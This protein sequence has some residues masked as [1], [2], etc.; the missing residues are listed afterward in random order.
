MRC[1]LA[2]IYKFSLIFSF[3]PDTTVGNILAPGRSGGF[4]ESYWVSRPTTADE[5][6]KWAN[7]RAQLLAGDIAITSYREA[8]YTY[9]GNKM[10]P[11]GVT[12]GNLFRPGG[13]LITTNSPD[14][15]L[16]CLARCDAANHTWNL[17]I[18]AVPDENITS[19]QFTPRP[20]WLASLN[21]YLA[22]LI[23]GADIGQKINFL[24]RDPTTAKARVLA[25]NVA[26]GVV[27]V[28][29]NLA[30][31]N[32]Q[33]FIR[34]NRVYDAAGQPV[35]GTYLVVN[36]VANADGTVDYTIQGGPTTTVVRPSGTVRKD[37]ILASPCNKIDVRIVGER[38]VG[39][40]SLAYRGRR[41]RSR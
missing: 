13:N 37:S 24:G 2:N 22:D 38:K 9:S 3:T 29:A 21:N 7:G 14:D 32:G 40:P 19:G 41:T 25:Y 8:L 5:R 12:V 35:K 39:R 18:R 36:Q 34:F 16:R 11:Q 17:F 23:T 33:D 26:P 27:K 30:L 1:I 4:S 20:D 10:T 6:N 15:A 28:N 31:N